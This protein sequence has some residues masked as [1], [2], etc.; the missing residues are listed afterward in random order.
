MN[1]NEQISRSLCYLITLLVEGKEEKMLQD[2][3]KVLQYLKRLNSYVISHY[4]TT[5]D[6]I[7]YVRSSLDT[8]AKDF[9]KSCDDITKLDVDITRTMNEMTEDDIL[10]FFLC[11]NSTQYGNLL[12]LKYDEIKYWNNYWLQHNSF[13][14]YE[15]LLSEMRSI[16]VDISNFKVVSLPFYKFR[17]INESEMYSEKNIMNR[18]M[19]GNVIEYANKLDGS[20]IQ[21]TFLNKNYSFYPYEHLLTSSGNIKNTELIKEAREWYESNLNYKYFVES[22]KEYTIIFEWI[23]MNDRHVVEYSLDDC[24]LW[25][26]GMRHKVTGELISYTELI[27]LAEQYGLRHTEIYSGTYDDIKKTL[28]EYKSNEKE[29]YVLNIDG[30]LVKLKC[31]DYCNMVGLIKTVSSPNTVIESI[32]NKTFD[33]LK[34]R[35][36]DEYRNRL[37]NTAN[38]VFYY[39]ELIDS[40]V[41]KLLYYIFNQNLSI[42]EVDRWMNQ[43]PRILKGYIKR[44]YFNRKKGI[45][46]DVINYLKANGLNNSNCITMTELEK[47]ITFLESFNVEDYLIH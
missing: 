41:N 47:R 33:D 7:E 40:T 43:L 24:G 10:N 25:L 39:L 32:N 21:I 19:R 35:I 22:F 44:Q 11:F 34:S 2:Y 28:Y 1:T 27:N 17:N 31:L 13:E 37:N 20:F 29:G 16:V 6:K 38:R 36:P 4:G 15:G 8:I 23:S 30:F 5:L 18:L 14:A 3:K 45:T 26:I 42:K 46:D 12:L 9:R